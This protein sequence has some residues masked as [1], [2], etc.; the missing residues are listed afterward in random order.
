MNDVCTVASD[1][2]LAHARVLAQS[3]RSV[4]P[5]SRCIL[6]SVEG[7]DGLLD[8]DHELFEV[9][10]IDDLELPELWRL[11]ETYSAFE[12]AVALKP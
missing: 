4:H 11:A 2:V 10:T 1:N 6:M 3:L 9:L 7:T 8:S 12:L 5:E